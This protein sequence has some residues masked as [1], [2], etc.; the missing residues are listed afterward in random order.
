MTPEGRV[1]AKVKRRLALLAKRCY[2]FMPVQTGYGKKGLD[3][4]LCI[5]S[6]FVAIETKADATKKMTELQKAIAEEI[7]EADGLVFLIYDDAT[8][9]NAMDQIEKQCLSQSRR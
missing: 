7:R 1:K 8:L 5:N 2:S 6:W 3:F 4:F 9:D